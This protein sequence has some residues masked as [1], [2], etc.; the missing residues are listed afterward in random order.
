MTTEN[1]ASFDLDLV[2]ATDVTATQKRAFRDAA[3][4]WMTI[5]ADSELTDYQTGGTIDCGDQYEQSVGTIDDLMIVAAVVEIDGPGGILGR[6][7]P[8]WV[9]AAKL[10]PVFGLMEFDD[11]D[12]ETV[13]RD[14]QLEPLILH[15][16]GHVLGIGT[17]WGRHGLLRQP[18]SQTDTLDTHFTGLLAAGA[19]D[20]AG[21]GDYTGGAKVPVE[22]TGGPGT[23]TAH[24]RVSVF[25]TELMIGWLANSP[26]LSAITIQSLADLGY[27]VNPGL[28]DAYGLPDREAAEAFRQDA[29]DLGNDIL[30]DPIVVVDRNGRIVRVIPP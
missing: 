9:R 22:N 12:L 23:R 14:G 27:T 25:G 5:L 10:L 8:C 11:A 26:P 2:F 17:L 28:A 16:M 1:R 13:E 6:A 20:A 29:I 7:G 21:G 24:W 30:R 18:S 15:E 4:R 19:F 3:Q